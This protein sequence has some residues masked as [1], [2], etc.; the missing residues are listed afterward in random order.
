[1]ATLKHIT[2]RKHLILTCQ[3][4]NSLGINQGTSGNI[5][6]RT[7]DGF[8]ISP[9]GIPY[10]AM[11]PEQVVAMDLD[12]GYHG[13]WLPSSEWRMH[14]D[15]FKARTEA[16]AIVHTHSTYATALS[17]LRIEVP[18]FHYM[19]GVTGGTTLRCS[20]YAS[21]GTQELSNTMLEA[22]EDR[23]ACLLANHGV[24]CFGP[25]LDKA[26]WLAGE[27]ETLCKQYFVATQAGLPIILTEEEMT[28][29]LARFKTYGKQAGDLADGDAPAVEAPT[30]RDVKPA[31]R[32][33]AKKPAP[34]KAPISKTA[35]KPPAKAAAKAPARRRAPR[36]TSGA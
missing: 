5:S 6:V 25:T 14:H 26:L 17:C 1:M 20:G 27:I 29:V 12:A 19:I 22:L 11:K 35:P 30:R 24:I 36:K 13:D 15:L 23:T 3:Q 9:S 4:M 8:L 28:G 16:G 18:A 32:T 10:G 34:K 31:R 2:L 33:A 21:F 7:P